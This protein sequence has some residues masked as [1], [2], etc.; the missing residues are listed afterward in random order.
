MAGRRLQSCGRRLEALRVPGMELEC[1]HAGCV[2][3]K[4]QQR[5]CVFS[6]TAAATTTRTTALT[7]TAIASAVTSAITTPSFTTALAAAALAT[8]LAPAALSTA[9]AA[10]AAARHVHRPDP[11]HLMPRRQ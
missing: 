1:I 4:L 5:S 8:A 7:T 9:I 2:P 6:V 10:G 3:A 11:R